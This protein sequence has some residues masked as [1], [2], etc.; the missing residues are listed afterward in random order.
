LSIIT[1]SHGCGIINKM[2][3]PTT[4]FNMLRFTSFGIALGQHY[5]WEVLEESQPLGVAYLH[6]SASKKRIDEDRAIAYP[7]HGKS[8]YVSVER[9]AGSREQGA[10]ILSPNF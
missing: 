10:G 3:L 2:K 6:P 7:N 5:A 1:K 8:Y 4:K 9:G